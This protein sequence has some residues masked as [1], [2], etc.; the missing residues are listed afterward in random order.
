M[1]NSAIAVSVTG[2]VTTVHHVFRLGW[3]LV[4]PGAVLIVGPLALLFWWNSTKSR[5]AAGLF[6]VFAAMV[7]L[8]FGFVDGFLDHVLKSL[9]L[10]NT[11]ILPGGDAEVVATAMH[12]WSPAASNVFYEG[13]GVLTFVAAVVAVWL[14]LA[15]VARAVRSRPA[16]AGN[17]PPVNSPR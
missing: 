3:D 2:V 14:G 4:F 11:T 9:G 17:R 1:R 16:P 12:L 8:W 10:D 6:G 7:A 15:P 5:V 13:T